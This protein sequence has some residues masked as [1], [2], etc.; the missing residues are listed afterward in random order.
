MTDQYAFWRGALEDN[1][2][3]P[4]QDGKFEC[5]FWKTKNRTGKFSAV[6]IWK[7]GDEFRIKVDENMIDP[8]KFAGRWNFTWQNPVTHDAYKS[9]MREGLWPGEIA[10]IGHNA[11]DDFSVLK[12][13]I[14]DSA[15]Q[16]EK[17]LLDLKDLSSQEDADKAANWRDALNKLKKKAD[18]K[19]KEEKDPLAQQVKEIDGKYNALVRRAEN[20]ANIIRDAL[21]KFMRKKEAEERERI[22][23]ERKKAEEDR[24][25]LEA[26]RAALAEQ[27][28]VL[29]ALEPE[30]PPMPEPEAPKP[31]RVG[32]QLGRATSFRSVWTADIKDFNAALSHFKDH[33]DII[34]LIERLCNAEARSK[35]RKAIPGV[36]FKE[37]KRAA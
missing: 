2:L 37:E 13:N 32:G 27:D 6:A 5:G 34:A 15:A 19:R 11:P 12:E 7:D 35:A 33:P 18:A 22:E 3:Y 8:E 31:V 26:E 24:R 1:Y 23:T 21:T 9:Y 28:I 25:R 20:V 16:A 36:E 10:G 17:W 30:L 29:A 14:E 4:M